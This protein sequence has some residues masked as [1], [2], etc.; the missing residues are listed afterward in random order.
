MNR[1]LRD[2]FGT[3]ADDE[4]TDAA[5]RRGLADILNALDNVID[6]NE[7]LA[8]VYA[9]AGRAM[10]GESPAAAAGETEAERA[11][12]RIGML[13]STITAAVKAEPDSSF[14]GGVSLRSARRYLYELR[15]GLENRTLA[16]EDA[17]RLIFVTRHALH[18][19]D[20]VLGSQHR[21]PLPEPV[22]ARIAD[23]RQLSIDLLD[24]MNDVQDEVLRLFGHSGDSA[25]VLV[26]QH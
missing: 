18:Q 25:R 26:P 10:P 6:D 11:C 19:A 2:A 4:A 13:E 17:F 14:L 21:M 9:S 7:A 1:R 20:M 23:L 22:L 15:T 8:R 12:A 16:E 3:G 24:Q 5:I